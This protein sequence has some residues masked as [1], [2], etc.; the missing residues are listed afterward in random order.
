MKKLFAI[1]LTLALGMS[2][3]ALTLDNAE[4]A[5]EAPTAVL[6]EETATSNAGKPGYNL[7]TGTTEAYTFDGDLELSNSSTTGDINV[8]WN[9]ANVYVDTTVESGNPVMRMATTRAHF[10]VNS[11]FSIEGTRP[12][13][14]SFKFK[15]NYTDPIYMS[16][17]ANNYGFWTDGTYNWESSGYQVLLSNGNE[18]GWTSQ[19]KTFN[20]GDAVKKSVETV[21]I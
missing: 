10:S 14:L 5:N 18:T 19:S 8:D 21:L 15:Y 11:P 3:A 9:Q 12:V 4:A 20:A 1:L 2:A 16:F 6:A 7:W 13:T 17:R